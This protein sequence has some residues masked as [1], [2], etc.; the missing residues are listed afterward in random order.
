MVA[1]CGARKTMGSSEEEKA[2]LPSLVLRAYQVSI[3][4]PQDQLV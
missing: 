2:E 1:S 3:A 4:S